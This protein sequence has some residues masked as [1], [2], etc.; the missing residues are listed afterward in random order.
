MQMPRRTLDSVYGTWSGTAPCEQTTN[1][2]PSFVQH[3]SVTKTPQSVLHFDSRNKGSV[4][5]TS[6]HDGVAVMRVP[7]AHSIGFGYAVSSNNSLLRWISEYRPFPSKY[8]VGSRKAPP[9]RGSYDHLGTSR[10]WFVQSVPLTILMS[11]IIIG[12]FYIGCYSLY[13]AR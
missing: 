4:S 11:F 6:N 3:T 1:G 5:H 12:R 8:L 10:I 9:I 13:T 2:S 7:S